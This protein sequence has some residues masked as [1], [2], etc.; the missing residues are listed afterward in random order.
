MIPDL[1][2]NSAHDIRFPGALD[3]LLPS[4][5]APAES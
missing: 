1:S 3:D 2:P 4:G 5:R